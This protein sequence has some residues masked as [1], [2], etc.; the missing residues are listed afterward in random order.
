MNSRRG[1][2]RENRCE[3]EARERPRHDAIGLD[4]VLEA[5]ELPAGVAHLDAGLPDVD[6]Y[7]LPHLPLSIPSS[8]S[9]LPLFQFAG[10]RWPSFRSLHRPRRR[11][12]IKKKAGDEVG[13]PPSIPRLPRRRTSL[14][15][16]THHSRLLDVRRH[17]SRAFKGCD[18]RQ[19]GPAVWT[20]VAV[21][22]FQGPLFLSSPCK[23]YI[24]Y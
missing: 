11:P 8:F 1:S 14:Q 6:A 10:L 23:L 13:E 17:L 22:W 4:A 18:A 24:L 9:D 3:T 7:D 2:N 12:R 20:P 15:Q 19:A 5:V 21:E 16:L